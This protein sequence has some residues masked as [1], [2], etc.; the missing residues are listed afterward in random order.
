MMLTD[1]SCCPNY[2]Q[3]P[4]KFDDDIVQRQLRYT[5]MLETVRIRQ[6]G[7]NVR[8]TFDEFI[9]LYRIL[10]PK[11]LERYICLVL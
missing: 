6:A 4:S 2:S 5:G 8:L 1:F 10:L 9:H 11:G 3:T 7:Y